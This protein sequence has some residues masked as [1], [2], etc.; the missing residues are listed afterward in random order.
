MQLH[1]VLYN[2]HLEEAEKL[3]RLLKKSIRFDVNSSYQIEVVGSVAREE[4]TIKDIDFL[5]ITSMMKHNFIETIYFADKSIVVT[6][7]AD[8]GDRKCFVHLLIDRK[9]PLKIDIFYATKKEKPFALLHHIGPKSYLLRIRRLAKLKGYLLNQYGLFHRDSDRRV[10]GEFK[11][12]C[13]IQ[14][15][16]DITCRPPKQRR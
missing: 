4:S 10:S 2:M 13:D 1:C 11:T 12:V 8:C 7:I 14:K 9:H 15:Y 6:K 5:V 16:L 3:A